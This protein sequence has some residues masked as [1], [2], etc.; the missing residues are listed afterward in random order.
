[1]VRNTRLLYVETM[2]LGQ[3]ASAYGTSKV[4]VEKIM[5]DQVKAN[6][7]FRGVSLRYFN[8]IG[9]H[10]SGRIGEDPSGIPN[11][12]LPFVAQVLVGKREQLSI[13][14]DDYATEDGTCERDYPHVMDLAEGHVAALDW[15]QKEKQFRGVE[16][17]DLGTGNSV[18]VLQIVEAFERACG[19]PI[20]C[21][22]APPREGDL[23]AFWADALKA[24]ELLGWQAKRSIEQMMEDTWRWQ[25]TNP[26]RYTV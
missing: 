10:D 25:S 15:M 2:P 24:N 22:F 23:A 16:N 4:M 21:Q 19:K 14:G 17:F 6:V 11:N 5:A 9:A 26:D 8:P 1:M 3:P 7:D 12:L 18:S 20:P 13:F